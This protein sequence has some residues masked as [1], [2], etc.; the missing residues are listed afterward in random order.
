MTFDT[1]PFKHSTQWQNPDVLTMLQAHGTELKDSGI[2]DTYRQELEDFASKIEATSPNSPNTAGM[3]D[4]AKL[5]LTTVAGVNRRSE[6]GPNH[7]QVLQELILVQVDPTTGIPDYF[8]Q[9]EVGEIIGNE[10]NHVIAPFTEPQL[11]IL[12]RQVKDQESLGIEVTMP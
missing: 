8:S 12:V 4:A 10:I 3:R 1:D 6:A 11:R 9:I 7:D 2:I 5:G